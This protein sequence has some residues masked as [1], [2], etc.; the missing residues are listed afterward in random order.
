LALRQGEMLIKTQDID[1]LVGLKDKKRV[2]NNWIVALELE[3]MDRYDYQFYLNI[4]VYD[5]QEFDR[6]NC[7]KTNFM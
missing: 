3:L 2:D 5:E 7:L 4:L 6:L 1:I